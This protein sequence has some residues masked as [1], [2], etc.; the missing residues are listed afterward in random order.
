[1]C[2]RA[3]I[4]AHPDVSKTFLFIANMGHMLLLNATF[5]QRNVGFIQAK[6]LAKI[7]GQPKIMFWG[8]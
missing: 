5:N 7:Q 8:K 2:D 6:G 1:M 4:K 3:T